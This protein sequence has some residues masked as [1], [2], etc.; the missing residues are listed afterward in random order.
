MACDVRFDHLPHFEPKRHKVLAAILFLMREAAKAGRTLTR[1]EIVKSIFRA[2]EEHFLECG[3]PVTFDNYVAMQRGPVGNAAIDML[4]DKIDWADLD[5][6]E[7]PW[8]PITLRGMPAYR[9]PATAVGLDCLSPSDEEFLSS[10]LAEVTGAGFDAMSESTHTHPAWL[11]A[12][13]AR[14]DAKAAPM[15]WRLFPNADAARIH[16]LA[17]ASRLTKAAS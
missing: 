13:G 8:E 2:D 1:G 3:R 15:D 17:A 6:V 16:E 12:W 9:R 7:A 4:T 5:L 14:G 10:A 11:A